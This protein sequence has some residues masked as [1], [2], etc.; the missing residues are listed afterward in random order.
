MNKKAKKS[1]SR[2]SNNS[3]INDKKNNS[4]N[5]LNYIK[6]PKKRKEI[7]G[8]I[9]RHYYFCDVCKRINLSVECIL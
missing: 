9:K 3:S 1:S 8:K 2:I 6:L 7:K 5:N 4:P